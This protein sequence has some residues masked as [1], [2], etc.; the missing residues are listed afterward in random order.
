MQTSFGEIIA[1]IAN[2][3]WGYPLLILLMGGGLYFL[4]SSRF[5]PFRYL[6]HAI[7][8]VR[9]KYDNEE[10]EGQ[11]KHYEA[12]ST[13]IAGTVGMGNIAGVAVAISI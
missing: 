6:G 3:A 8:I 12:L 11:L 13:A 7:Q 5:A 2:I 10:E 1:Q 9:G 4:I